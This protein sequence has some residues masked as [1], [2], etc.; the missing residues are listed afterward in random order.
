MPI[1]HI[2][3]ALPHPLPPKPCLLCLYFFLEPSVLGIS[4]H[5]VGFTSSMPESTLVLCTLCGQPLCVQLVSALEDGFQF[6]GRLSEPIWVPQLSR[7]VQIALLPTYPQ[8]IPPL[9]RQLK[10]CL[11][12]VVGKP[13]T[14][15][16]HL[17]LPQVF[18]FWLALLHQTSLS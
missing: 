8:P 14:G 17:V 18:H 10:L 9:A 4:H 2:P 12:L 16:L 1:L 15:V 3:Y 6:I 5:S 13:P 11:P 7:G